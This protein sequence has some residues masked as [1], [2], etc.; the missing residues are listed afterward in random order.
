MNFITKGIG[1]LVDFI[2]WVAWG[3][4]EQIDR[5]IKMIQDLLESEKPYLSNKLGYFEYTFKREITTNYGFSVRTDEYV[6]HYSK[7]KGKLVFRNA[8]FSRH[9]SGRD[10]GDND[11]Y[12]FH[13]EFDEFE[14]F[15]KTKLMEKKLSRRGY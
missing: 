9:I 12:V 2:N 15:L 7:K 5:I 14:K 1:K 10:T 3:R 13:G 4:N 6:F 11:L 8:D